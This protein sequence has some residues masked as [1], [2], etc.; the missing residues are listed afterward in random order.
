MF[1]ITIKSDLD[2]L[3]RTLT[4]L[5]R[6]QLPF[7][8]ARALNETIKVMEAETIKLMQNRFDS[9]T[10]WTLGA[11]R[12]IPATKARQTATLL[13]KDRA[14]G[15]DVAN[16]YLRLQEQGGTAKPMP[17]RFG[18]GSGQALVK[19]VG[20]KLNA[21]GNLPFKALQKAK[22]KPNTFIGKVN[23]VGGLWQRP[24]PFKAPRGK[25]RAMDGAVAKFRGRLKLL[26][27][28]QPSRSYTKRF[29]YRKNV[30]AVARRTFVAAMPAA[31]AYALRTARPR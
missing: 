24:K 22:A 19:P 1:T 6:K 11:F 26:V 10:K 16:E 25:A 17:P 21:F 5:Q 3:S 23:G 8:T 12:T 18:T 31:L 30:E 28:F 15:S 14:G 13:L 29:G 2:K 9:P 4:D 20:L 27:R 7:A